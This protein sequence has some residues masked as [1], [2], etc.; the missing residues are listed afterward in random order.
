M[1]KTRKNVTLA[2]PRTARAGEG[3]LRRAEILVCS[4]GLRSSSL[5]VVSFV[6]YALIIVDKG[7]RKN[8]VK[9]PAGGKDAA[10]PSMRNR[11]SLYRTANA[12]A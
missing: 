10:A 6:A 8:H 7:R 5:D 11:W 4:F 9:V 2:L 12:A 1:A 3:F